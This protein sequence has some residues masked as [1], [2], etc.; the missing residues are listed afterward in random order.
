ML[1]PNGSESVLSRGPW[2]QLVQVRNVEC[3][4]GKRRN[5]CRIGIADTMWT[6]PAAVRVAGKTVTG[7][8]ECSDNG[9]TFTASKYGKNGQIG[10]AHV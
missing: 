8:L 10:R 2:S 9:Y 3:A 7:F 5:T 1:Y 4:D 6:C